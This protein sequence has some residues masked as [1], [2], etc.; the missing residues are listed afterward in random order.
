MKILTSETFD[1]S[2]KEKNNIIKFYA[3]WCGPCKRLAPKLEDMSNDFTN[4]NF[5]EVNVEYETELASKFGVKGIPHIVHL[6]QEGKVVN[7][8]V[9]SDINKIL[10]MVNN[11]E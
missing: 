6:D 5:F 7:Q 3:D 11:I 9:D 8:V 2:I 4:L 10:E 1:E